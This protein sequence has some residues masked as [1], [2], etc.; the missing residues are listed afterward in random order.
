MFNASGDMVGT[1][2]LNEQPDG[3]KIKVKIKGLEP[4]FHGIHVHEFPKC[5][6]PD[7]SNAGNHLNPEGKEHGLM[8][9]DGAHL[10]DLPNVEADGS[11]AVDAE[12]MLAGATMKEGN[13]SILRGEGTSLIVTEKQDDGV[14]QPS[15]N[16][17]A[18]IICGKITA[19]SKTDKAESPSNPT[20]T[21]KKKE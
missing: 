2:K 14:S 7:F 13:K 18:R 20:E 10:G 17:G 16:S 3:V 4:G 8:R 1:A 11:G 21:K 9:T 5:K 15:G 6:G 12:L 19:A